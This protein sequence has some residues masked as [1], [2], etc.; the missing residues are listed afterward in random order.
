[1]QPQTGAREEIRDVHL[2]ALSLQMLHMG[3]AHAATHLS[4]E[5]LVAEDFSLV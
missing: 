5:V 3:W 2:K 1:M 4:R